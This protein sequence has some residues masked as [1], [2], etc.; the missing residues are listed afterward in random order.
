MMRFACF[1]LAA[2]FSIVACHG[3]APDR[4]VIDFKKTHGTVRAIHGIN[5]GPLA[6]GGLIDLT[7]AHREL[8][9]PFVRLHD[10]HWPN[11]DVVDIHVV[12]PD[13]KADPADPA[14]YDFKRTD[15]YI[16]AIRATGARIVYRLGES[17][18]HTPDKRFVH[19]PSDPEKWAAICLGIIRHYN[20]GWANGF[21]YNIRYWE[22][23]NEPEN[24]P[25]MWT[26]TDDQFFA[27]YR[28]AA[29]AIKNEF[30]TV[31]VGGP[32][33]GH[34]GTLAGDAFTPSKFVRAFLDHCQREQLP[35]EFFSWH[36]YTDNPIELV[37]RAKGIRQL[38][39]D[40]GFRDTESHLNEWN[41]LPGNTWTPILASARPTDRQ[42]FYERMSGAE[43][44][45]FIITSLIALQD[46]PVDMLNLFHG[47]LGGFGLFN[48]HGVPF[49]NYYAL[50]AFAALAATSHRLQ[51]AVPSNT[52]WTVAAGFSES[53]AVILMAALKPASVELHLTNQPTRFSASL[54]RI[55]SSSSLP[56]VIEPIPGHRPILLD[57]SSPGAL[58]MTLQE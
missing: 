57:L 38:L 31:K 47:E 37:R 30:P 1:A 10:C 2:L 42:R 55:D 16:A 25:A 32:A 18:E 8:K 12:F 20:H 19:P 6:P 46:A 39:D 54:Q 13:F 23:W 7:L 22:I 49:P 50:R 24:R 43:G 21:H 44:S 17:I 58:F 36:C 4:I 41:Y 27:L 34:S 35:L 53:R 26:G 29:R 40:R 9:L 52:S 11:P 56:P 3:A 51:T 5:K 28:A 15:E 45:A 14:S 48:E 33:V